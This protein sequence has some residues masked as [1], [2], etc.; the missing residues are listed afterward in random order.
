MVKKEEVEERGNDGRLR[1]L[2]QEINIAAAEGTEIVGMEVIV[3]VAV[4]V[5]MKFDD[6]KGK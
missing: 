4:V 2:S 1:L 6:L 3:V 5:V